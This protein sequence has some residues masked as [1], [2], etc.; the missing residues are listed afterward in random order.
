MGRSWILFYKVLC[1]WVACQGETR[2]KICRVLGEGD[3]GV[4]VNWKQ[5]E[6]CY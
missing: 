1:E 6:F 5:G 2:R 4:Q 3:V